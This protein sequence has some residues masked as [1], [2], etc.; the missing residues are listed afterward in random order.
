MYSLADR[1]CDGF[2]AIEWSVL[3]EFTS[4]SLSNLSLYYT[5]IPGKVGHVDV[6][7]IGD[8]QVFPFTVIF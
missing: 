1:N 5:D 8:R 7:Q 2:P 6:W 3:Y 4:S